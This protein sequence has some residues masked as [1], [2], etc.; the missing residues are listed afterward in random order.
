MLVRLLPGSM[1]VASLAALIVSVWLGLY[2]VTRSPRSYL[3]WAGR[4]HPLVPV[5]P[6]PGQP[7]LPSLR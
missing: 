5:S 1:S 2:I 7:D 6:L 3:S 4:R